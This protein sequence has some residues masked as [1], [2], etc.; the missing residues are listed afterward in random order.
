MREEFGPAIEA[1]ERDLQE[2]IQKTLEIKRA[3][4]TLMKH[5]G[6]E[7]K[8]ADVDS[9]RTE[10][11]V[12][13]KAD[14]FYGRKLIPAIREYLELHRHLGPATPR[15]IFDGLKRGGYSF[16]TANEA[17]ALAHLRSTLRKSPGTFHRLPNG[18]S[19]GLLAWYP[20]VRKS[21]GANREDDIGMTE[22]AHI[23]ERGSVDGSDL[24]NAGETAATGDHE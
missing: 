6:G 1:L 4:N 19:Y 20:D 21:K 15:E 18:N 12:V 16:G 9:N 2:A 13:I 23:D 22:D 10:A 7:P 14:R 3:I 24:V 11:S 17:N 8:Y 5:A